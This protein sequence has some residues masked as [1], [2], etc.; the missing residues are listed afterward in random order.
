[1]RN[2]L[3]NLRQHLR[4]LYEYKYLISTFVTRDFKARFRQAKLGISWAIVQ[5]LFM[6]VV[7]TVVFSRLLKVS[8]DGAPYP[9]F[10]FVALSVWTFF[11][12][13]VTAGSV[14][15]IYNGGLVKK[16]YFPREVIPISTVIS[17]LVDFGIAS[18]ITILFLLIYSI[19]ISWHVV[20]LPL[21]LLIQVLLG[22]AITM[23]TASL[24]VVFR[25][26]EFAFP[27]FVQLL[28]YASPIIYSIRNLQQPYKNLLYLN[29]ITGI[30]EGYRSILIYHELPN[31][32]LLGVS[33][34]FAMIIL[35]I[36]Y[37]L[38]KRIERYMADVL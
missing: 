13:S 25:D 30:V 26:L 7:F 28:M 33:L 32:W 34:G 2:F 16:V 1:M 23:S 8:T 27:F 4:E 3:K 35:V 17:S 19:G 24:T 22:L 12:R 38:F 37:V 21:V 36:S 5:P 11:S 18:L 6:T 29:P 31:L 20:L 15:L 9:V 14:S 10:S